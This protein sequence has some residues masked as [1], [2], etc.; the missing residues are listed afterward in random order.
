VS[1]IVSISSQK[2]RSHLDGYNPQPFSE[3]IS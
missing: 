2:G 3:I 1:F